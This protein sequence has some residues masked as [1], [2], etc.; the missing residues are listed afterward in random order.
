MSIERERVGTTTVLTMA[1]PEKLNALTLE[2]VDALDG[3]LAGARSD[4]SRAVV[5]AGAGRGF[6]AGADVQLLARADLTSARRFFERYAE[7]L[8]SLRTYPL[9]LVAAVHGYAVG[10]GAEMACE[11]DFRVLSTD[12]VFGYPDVALGSV[13]ATVQRLI[14]LVGEPAARRLVLLGE[15]L[16]SAEA[17]RLG[18]AYGVHATR[19]DAMDAAVDLARRLSELP[20]IAVELAKE[21]LAS[22]LRVDPRRELKLNVEAMVLCQ[23]TDEQRDRAEAFL[24]RRRGTG[25]ST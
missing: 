19:Q 17:L 7:L 12:A 1:R 13:P 5:L 8:L 22:A 10:G 15:R 4:G 24:N 18:L 11:A 3:L 6:C 25:G 9:P 21:G 14:A 2:M 16:G 20:L 23:D